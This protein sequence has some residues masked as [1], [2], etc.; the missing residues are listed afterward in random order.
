MLI[1]TEER[2]V[3][4]RTPLVRCRPSTVPAL[5]VVYP[6]SGDGRV[7]FDRGSGTVNWWWPFYNPLT[8]KRRL[9]TYVDKL[10]SRRDARKLLVAQG[11]VG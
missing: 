3:V 4:P 5:R 2:P 11:C 8:P 6:I 7:L 9:S 1:L 10:T